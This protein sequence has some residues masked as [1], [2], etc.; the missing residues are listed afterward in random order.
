MHASE[1]SCGNPGELEN[2]SVTLEEEAGGTGSI[3]RYRCNE[4]F[5]LVGHETRK[6]Q[7]N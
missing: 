1:S 3:A 7:N 5:L 4:G 6:G 2:G